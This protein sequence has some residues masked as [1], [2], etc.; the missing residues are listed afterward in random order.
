MSTF[1][2]EKDI[3]KLWI[4]M[5]SNLLGIVDKN[6]PSKISTTKR[7]QPWITSETKRILRKKQYWFNKSKKCNSERVYSKYKDIKK[8]S[9]RL[10]RKAY[11]SYVQDLISNDS[12]NKKLWAFIRGKSNEN[13]GISDLYD[14]HKIIQ[15]PTTKANLFSNQFCSVFSTPGK[16]KPLESQT[17]FLSME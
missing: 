3:N 14:D 8:A 11:N 2:H 4:H 6:V 12:N 10:C 7:H 15:D 5:K 13:S 1:R 17:T 16:T 9:Q